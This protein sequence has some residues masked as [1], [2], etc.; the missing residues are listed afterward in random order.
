MSN[1]KEAKGD[2]L[3]HWF[4]AICNDGINESS[5]E[6]SEA[7]A[8]EITQNPSSPFQS[9]YPKGYEFDPKDY[10]VH[11]MWVILTPPAKPPPLQ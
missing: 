8:E 7:A 11:G 10:G 2:V 1:R 4:D 6:K 9:K 3:E 5:D